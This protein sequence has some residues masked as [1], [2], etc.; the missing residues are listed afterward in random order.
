MLGKSRDILRMESDAVVAR[1]TGLLQRNSTPMLGVHRG[2][3]P[4]SS[5]DTPSV[6]R[7]QQLTIASDMVKR[8]FPVCRFAENADDRRMHLYGEEV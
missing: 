6:L 4:P 5:S 1:M 3:A 2:G 7:L 8:R